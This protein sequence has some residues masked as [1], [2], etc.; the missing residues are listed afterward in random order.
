MKQLIYIICG[1]CVIS[2]YA[3]NT[4][5]INA[6]FNLSQVA[7][8]DLEP[9][10]TTVTLNLAASTEA[11]EKAVVVM[12]NNKK[13]INFSSAVTST[14]APRSILIKID[15]GQ[16]P[17]GI[18]LKLSTSN[19]MGIGK[20]VLGS[21]SGILTLNS[22]PQTIISN[23]RGAFTGDGINNGYELTYY[24]E[25]YDYKLLDFNQAAALSISLTLTDL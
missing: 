3:Q 24:L 1:F 11:G 23:I 9:N 13:W 6:T 18:Y 2:N 15:D 17:P 8:L 20:G 10:Y 19:Y 12:A 16:V 25:I 5:S 14:A 4:G 22:T 7:M 21:P